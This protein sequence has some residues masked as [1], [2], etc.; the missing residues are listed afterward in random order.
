MSLKHEIRR[1]LWKA[2]YDFCR[3]TPESHGF[4]RRRKLL[5]HYGITTVL[6]VGANAGQYAQQ[7]REDVGYQG[8]IVSFEPLSTAFALLERHAEADPAWDV[9]RLAIG[10][11]D[12]SAEINVAGNSYSSSLLNMLP[13]HQ[14]SAPE[15]SYVGKE[16]VQVATLDSLFDRVC[17]DAQGVYLKI[18]TQG[19]ESKVI[20][21]AERSLPRI[22]TVQMELSLVPLYE[23]ELLFDEMCALMG[24]KG[25]TLV[26]LE[27]GFSDPASGQLLQVDGIFHRL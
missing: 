5:S 3:I 7:L 17:A 6:D 19:F 13:S 2:G 24:R 21:G 16:S 15:S 23:G 10:D 22:S 25:Y 1:T 9:F 26:A 20:A 14:K 12:G 8:R 18:D 27:N 4:A 11:A